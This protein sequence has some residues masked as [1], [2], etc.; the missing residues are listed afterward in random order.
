MECR[1][2]SL[3]FALLRCD[4]FK[5]LAPP[6]PIRCKAK[7][8]H[9]KQTFFRALGA[10]SSHWPFVIFN[11]VLI[12]RW[13]IDWRSKTSNS[14]CLLNSFSLVSILYLNQEIRPHLSSLKLKLAMTLLRKHLK[15]LNNLKTNAVQKLVSFSAVFWMPSLRD[16]PKTA[17]KETIK[18]RAF[19]ARELQST[20]HSNNCDKFHTILE[21]LN[22]T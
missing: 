21:L 8:N 7:T 12:G 16:I 2:Q 14:R 9:D 3:W 1:K 18:K 4:R 5:K 13:N 6:Q 15:A 19:F 22:V 11:F 17:A 20:I 10:L